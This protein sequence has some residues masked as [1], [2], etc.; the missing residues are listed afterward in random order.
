M[1][2]AEEFFNQ[3]DLLNRRIEMALEKIQI[4]KSMT[5]KVTMSLEGEQVSHSRNL[6]SFEDSV[7]RLTEAKEYAEALTV[8]YCE[9]VNFITEQMYK[10]TDLDDIQILT[11][12]FLKHR[13]IMET[14]EDLHQCRASVVKKTA[15]ALKKLNTYLADFDV[16]QFSIHLSN[17]S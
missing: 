11:Y 3:L 15:K 12:R 16:Q 4:Y 10:L 5:E 9:L 13:T 2:T 1:I 6:T 7:I 8:R 14:A 17:T